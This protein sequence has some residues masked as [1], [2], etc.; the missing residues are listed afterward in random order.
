MKAWKAS[1]KPK[2][3]WKVY[4]VETIL[5]KRKIK[6]EWHYLVKWKGFSKDEA[7]SLEPCEKLAV[8]VPELVEAFENRKLKKRRLRGV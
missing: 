2:K 4:E 8:D 6:G 5:G 7:E 1:R 3:I